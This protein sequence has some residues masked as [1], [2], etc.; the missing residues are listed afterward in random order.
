MP[1][2]LLTNGAST[3]LYGRVDVVAGS[4][5]K[6]VSQTRKLDLLEGVQVD[7]GE[8]LSQPFVCKGQWA[9]A[10][11]QALAPEAPRPRQ[12]VVIVVA[13]RSF[14]ATTFAL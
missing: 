1:E 7:R 14:G 12:R 13:P 10:W 2:V 9:E 5:N 6:F 4:I 8:V 3:H 11:Q